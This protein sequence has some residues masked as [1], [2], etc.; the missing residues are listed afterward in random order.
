MYVNLKE[1]KAGRTF[2]AI[3]REQEYAKS[4][5]VAKVATATEEITNFFKGIRDEYVAARK[6]ELFPP[7]APV[8]KEWAWT[9]DYIQNTKSWQIKLFIPLAI[10][11][12]LIF[13]AK[14][15]NLPKAAVVICMV[16]TAGSLIANTAFAARANALAWKWGDYYRTN[17][18]PKVEEKALEKIAQ[19]EKVNL[20][21]HIEWGFLPEGTTCE[22]IRQAMNKG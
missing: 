10:C 19:G 13:T 7:S 17:Y 22:D 15:T 18:W 16:T 6:K 21:Q 5:R 11:C 20:E 1:L 3:E 8:L 14:A 4:M 12:L 9:D 2:G